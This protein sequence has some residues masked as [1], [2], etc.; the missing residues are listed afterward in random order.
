VQYVTVLSGR[1]GSNPTRSAGDRVPP[2]GSVWTFAL[3]RD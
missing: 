2:G 1:G 3:M